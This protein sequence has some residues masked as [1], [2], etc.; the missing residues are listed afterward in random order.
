[1]LYWSIDW[2]GGLRPVRELLYRA[3]ISY[4]SGF[5]NSEVD[6]AVLLSSIRP[7][8]GINRNLTNSVPRHRYLLVNNRRSYVETWK[9]AVERLLVCFL[10]GVDSVSIGFHTAFRVNISH[11]RSTCFHSSTQERTVLTNKLRAA[12]SLLV[13]FIHKLPNHAS[14][15][16]FPLLN[17]PN[18][19]G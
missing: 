5:T 8:I 15:C 18:Q 4:T 1:M 14:V 6:F 3:S 7:K 16:L 19:S 10:G 11:H 12:Y 17:S 2:F 9:N 13:V